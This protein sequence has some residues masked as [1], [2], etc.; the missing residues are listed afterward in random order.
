[1]RILIT[2]ASGSIGQKL[3]KDLLKLNKYQLR[4]LV[5][6]KTKIKYRRD[7]IG[8]IEGDL[9]DSTSLV[10][11]ARGVKGVIHLAGLTHSHNP[12]LY[13]KINTIGTKNLLKAS[14]RNNVNKF[15]FVSSRTAS[16]SGGAYARS[17]FLAEE[18]V[19][20]FKQHWIIL[21]I[22]EV[23]GANEKE[24]INKLIHLIRK[25][26]FI[27]IVGNGE[28]ELAPIYID[29]AV[30]AIMRVIEKD[31]IFKKKYT[32]AG[33]RQYSYAEIIEILTSKMGLKRKKVYCPIFF[34]KLFAYFCRKLKRE[35]IYEDQIPRLLS[36]KPS[37]ITEA[38]A[39]LNFDPIEFKNGVEKILKTN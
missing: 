14:E 19:K 18:Q 37:D 25:S 20:H 7:D 27:P 16:E 5:S 32:I 17:K 6:D 11:A 21:N 12:E 15:V 39:D 24:A 35:L 30:L 8:I 38:R 9:L 31:N 23:Y 2:G 33:P 29:D 4:L 28:Y 13:Y 3:I 22:A 1:M 26:Y 34:I 10:E 36:S